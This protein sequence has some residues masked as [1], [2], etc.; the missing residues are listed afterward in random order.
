M[1][2]LS[3]DYFLTMFLTICVAVTGIF[4]PPSFEKS[5]GLG[6]EQ[7][8]KMHCRIFGSCIFFGGV[9]LLAGLLDLIGTFGMVL[10][11]EVLFFGF[12]YFTG[13]IANE[14]DK[15]R[16][17]RERARK[18]REKARVEQERAQAEHE[19]AAEEARV[20]E[21]QEQFDLL[22]QLALTAYLQN[23]VEC[24]RSMDLFLDEANL[25]YDEEFMRELEGDC[26]SLTETYVWR[27]EL[28]IA[29]EHPELKS[30]KV[31][32]DIARDLAMRLV[33]KHLLEYAR[34]RSCTA[35]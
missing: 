26:L 18:E 13:L 6:S 25:T 15:A 19:R 1:E 17:E 28:A 11:G 3:A 20:L 5:S 16:V 27:R 33:Q 4:A 30:S 34:E 24:L 21:L 32:L 35:S 8:N 12:M 31:F 7:M 29:L 10:A 9:F 14:S 2:I 22:C 23:V